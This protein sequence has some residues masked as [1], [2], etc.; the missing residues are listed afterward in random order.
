MISD[1]WAGMDSFFVPGTEIL[2]AENSRQVLTFLKELD[3]A[4]VAAIGERARARV[5]A[6]HTSDRRAEQFEAHVAEVLSSKER[7]Q[8]A[9]AGVPA[10]QP[11]P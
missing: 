9:L 7:S 2:L 10:G 3:P 11:R 5:L 4:E 8:T 1:T 6:E